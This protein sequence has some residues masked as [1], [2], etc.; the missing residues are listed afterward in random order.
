MSANVFHEFEKHRNVLAS[1]NNT[2]KTSK[3]IISKIE[4]ELSQIFTKA[5]SA[6]LDTTVL[7]HIYEQLLKKDDTNDKIRRRYLTKWGSSR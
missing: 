4:K 1:L 2:M 7:N 5:R 6:K 3:P